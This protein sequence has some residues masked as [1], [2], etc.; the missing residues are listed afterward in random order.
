[1][2][3]GCGES[4][5]ES[6][7]P[8]SLCIVFG[9]EPHSEAILKVYQASTTTNTYV[10]TTSSCLGVRLALHERVTTNSTY[11]RTTV[12]GYRQLGTVLPKS[13]LAGKPPSLT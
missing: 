13:T 1:M 2:W 10:A 3:G 8:R 9:G 4:L 7:L 5:T 12:A 11:T 6:T